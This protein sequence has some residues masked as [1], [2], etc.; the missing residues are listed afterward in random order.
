MLADIAFVRFLLLRQGGLSRC[1]HTP[2][3]F[4]FK[5]VHGIRL[6]LSIAAVPGRTSVHVGEGVACKEPY[7][8]AVGPCQEELLLLVELQAVFV[9]R[10][11]AIRFVS[12]GIVE[13]QGIH[14]TFRCD[15]IQASCDIQQLGHIFHVSHTESIGD[16]QAIFLVTVVPHRLAASLGWGAAP[17]LLMHQVPWQLVDDRC[18]VLTGDVAGRIDAEHGDAQ[19]VQLH[20]MF[21]QHVTS[22]LEPSVPV[23]KALEVTLGAVPR[24]FT[25]WTREVRLFDGTIAHEISQDIVEEFWPLPSI[26]RVDPSVAIVGAC[27]TDAWHHCRV[28]RLQGGWARGSDVVQDHIHHDLD[29]GSAACGDH[30]SQLL[31][32]AG[33]AVQAEAYGLILGIPLATQDMLR[34][35]RNLHCPNA[36]GAKIAGTF[37]RDVHIVPLPKL[38]VDGGPPLLTT[39]A[40][41]WLV[42]FAELAKHFL[43]LGGGGRLQQHSTALALPNLTAPDGVSEG[44]A[45]QTPRFLQALAFAGGFLSMLVELKDRARLHLQLLTSTSHFRRSKVTPP[46]GCQPSSRRAHGAAA[47]RHVA[48]LGSIHKGTQVQGHAALI[49]VH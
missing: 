38:H 9:G 16:L 19:V 33:T 37:L 2:R 31:R 34:H 22:G 21:R 15:A 28:A 44:V 41:H 25:L 46:Q 13:G 17:P 43:A 5:E 40:C 8:H 3:F 49:L 35:W 24:G 18:K 32:A 23:W 48:D 7:R 10:H 12:P 1:R 47:Q 4:V 42:V 29:P 14:G 20:E 36:I 39:W 30:L 6:A 45:F 27:P 26:L 11:E